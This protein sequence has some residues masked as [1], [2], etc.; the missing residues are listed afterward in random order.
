MVRRSKVSIQG[1]KV[2]T[3][4]VLKKTNG[5]TMRVKRNSGTEH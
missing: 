3:I 4:N 5:V 1:E 2:K